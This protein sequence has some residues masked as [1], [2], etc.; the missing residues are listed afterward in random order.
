MSWA[1]AEFDTIAL[2]DKRLD[3]RAVLLAEQLAAKPGSSIPQACGSW[4]ETQAA[5]RFFDNE[6][7][8]WSGILAAHW[9]AS[10]ERMRA[11]PV[12]LCLQD[13]TELNFNGQRS[14]GLGPLS[15]ETQRGM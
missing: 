1:A 15:Y 4:A 3:K 9:R 8:V 14:A 6:E 2:G 7:V 11:H 5:Y 12:V 13:T 10:I